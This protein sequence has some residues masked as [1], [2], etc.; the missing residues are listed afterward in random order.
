[1][2]NWSFADTKN[3]EHPAP[4][5]ETIERIVPCVVRLVGGFVMSWGWEVWWG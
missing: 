5:A 4:V 3:S 1:M 2:W